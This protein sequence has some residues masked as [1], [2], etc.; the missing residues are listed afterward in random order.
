MRTEPHLRSMP[1]IT[2]SWLLAVDAATLVGMSDGHLQKPGLHYQD[3]TAVLRALGI[4][5]DH[6]T[7][8]KE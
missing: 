3:F 4:Q 8:T 7:C 6:R 5:S 1:V 2:C